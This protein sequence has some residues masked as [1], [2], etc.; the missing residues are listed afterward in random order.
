MGVSINCHETKD[1]FNS[2]QVT[3]INQKRFDSQL[4]RASV[5]RSLVDLKG[6]GEVDEFRECAGVEGA[7]REG[8]CDFSIDILQI[9]AMLLRFIQFTGF[10]PSNERR[11]AREC[12]EL[13]T[14]FHRSV[15]PSTQ[16][17]FDGR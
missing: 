13:P 17:V 10:S 7:E 3:K 11:E 4:L 6:S 14:A 12:R 2:P 8:V 1:C 16:A 15:E 9:Q 5:H